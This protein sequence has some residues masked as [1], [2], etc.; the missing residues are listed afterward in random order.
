MAAFAWV[1]IPLAIFAALLFLLPA[2]VL[3]VNVCLR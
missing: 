3:A 2:Y 1:A